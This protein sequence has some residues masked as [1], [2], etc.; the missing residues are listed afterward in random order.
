MALMRRGR[1]IFKTKHKGFLETRPKPAARN[2][3]A[4]RGRNGGRRRVLFLED[5]VPLRRLGSG[6]VRANDCVHAI[7]AAGYDVTV[8]PGKNGAPH[9][10]MSLFGDLPETVEV[11][12]DRNINMLPPFLAERPDYYDLVWVSRTHNLDPHPGDVPQG[13]DGSGPHPL[14]SRYRSRDDGAR[15]GAPG[16]GR[17]AQELRID[18]ALRAEFAEAGCCR[19]IT[20]VNKAEVELLRR[21]GLPNV[22]LLGTH[23]RA[24]ADAGR[25]CRARWVVDGCRDPSGR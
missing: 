25:L 6:F 21:I 17:R 22:S 3:A 14:H 4:A 19:H 13:G 1:R 23:A 11:M 16:V 15:R 2:L 10:V 7:A 9:D 18:A 8:F 12:H 20:A 24:G 5:T